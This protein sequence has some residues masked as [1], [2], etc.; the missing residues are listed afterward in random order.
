MGAITKEVDGNIV[1]ALSY[2]FGSD[3]VRVKPEQFG[4]MVR[5]S[6]QIRPLQAR[7]NGGMSFKTGEISLDLADWE[8]VTN[9]VKT[10]GEKGWPAQVAYAGAKLHFLLEEIKK[11]GSLPVA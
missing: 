4:S 8:F 7:E 2:V 6:D 10:I 3:V 11:N 9:A 5:V 1:L